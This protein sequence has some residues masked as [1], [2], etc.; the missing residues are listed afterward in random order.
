MKIIQD[1]DGSGKIVFSDPEIE[2]LKKQPYIEFPAEGMKH[3][4]NS[5]MNIVASINERVPED[6]KDL[7][8][9]PKQHI[10]PKDE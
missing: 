4:A 3:I 9:Q 7:L 6:K 5:L 1:E 10:S 2:L 8:T